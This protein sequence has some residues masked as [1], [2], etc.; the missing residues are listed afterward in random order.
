MPKKRN[1]AVLERIFLEMEVNWLGIIFSFEN[2][3]S[4]RNPPNFPEN[5][6]VPL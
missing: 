5:F 2:G 6:A 3:L 1:G 4:I